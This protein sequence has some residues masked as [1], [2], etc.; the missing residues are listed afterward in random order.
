MN[1]FS[2]EAKLV[3]EPNFVGMWLIIVLKA[4]HEARFVVVR[5]VRRFAAT[6]FNYARLEKVQDN[7]TPQKSSHDTA[8]I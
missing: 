4:A 8:H 3:T 1:I 5:L 6:D 7:V 2:Q